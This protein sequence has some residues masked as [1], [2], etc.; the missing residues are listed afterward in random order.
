MFIEPFDAKRH[1]RQGVTAL[2]STHAMSRRWPDAR[3]AWWVT[4]IG[5]VPLPTLQRL[6]D[7]L[8]HDK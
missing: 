2:G 3:G 6:L 7:N 8:R 4:L 5:E 1:V